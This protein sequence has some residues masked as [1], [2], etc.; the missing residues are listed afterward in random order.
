MIKIYDGRS[1]FYQWDLERQL[2]ISDPI[3]D[4]VHFS[5]KMSDKALVVAVKE[6]DGLRVADV[7]NILLQA[8]WPIRAYAYCGD[9]YTKECATFKVNERTRPD[10]YVYTETEVKRWDALANDIN[11]KVEQYE[12]LAI[13]NEAFLADSGAVLEELQKA[14]NHERR[15][16]QLEK[17]ISNDYFVTD[18]STEYNKIVDANACP[19]AEID[20]VGG[21]SYKSKNLTDAGTVQVNKYAYVDISLSA[22]TMYYLSTYITSDDT[23]DTD[24]NVIALRFVDD[25]YYYISV[26]RGKRTP[27]SFKPS[28]NVNR[29][30]LFAGQNFPTSEGD[31]ATWA[32]IM[33]TTENT[34][35][36]EPYFEGLR[37]TAVSELVSEGA[38]LIPFPYIV[39][40]GTQNGTT[41]TIGD[42]GSIT[43]DKTPTSGFMITFAEWKNG[44]VFNGTYTMSTGVSLPTGTN[45]SLQGKSGTL[46]LLST[47]SSRT[48][49]INGTYSYLKLWVSVDG[50]FSN[51]KLYPMLNY[52][53]TAAPYKPYRAD[54]VDTFTIPEELRAF[55]ADKGYGKGVN[56]DYYNYIDFDRKVFVQRVKE[57]DMGLLNWGY[58]LNNNRHIFN[59]NLSAYSIQGQTSPDIPI[60]A[61]AED[62]RAV[63]VNATWVDRDMAY[64]SNTIGN[65]TIEIVDNRYTNQ[66]D[67]KAAVSGKKLM[68]ALETPIEIDISEYL[69]EDNY[70]EVEAGGTIRAINEYNQAAPTSIT[71][72]L[73][74]GS[75]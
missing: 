65:Q 26:P 62:Y 8:I 9:C 15:I 7:P 13:E 17:H 25:T 70:I 24:E 33:I 66:T 54:A 42:D 63:T 19:Y 49:N 2:I 28:K 20:K 57:V 50:T 39:K 22:G 52:G 10:D 48:L 75:I 61:L 34:D 59:A 27:V 21:M 44:R 47:G 69:T 43:L 46:T 64:N 51:V 74:E 29:L 30:T 41:Y 31:T 40:S 67:F 11:E 5:N 73:K 68:Y 58:R 53:T 3:V 55:L 71:Y 16:T 56:A 32:D 23:D 60:N 6:K 45:L 36:Y 37:D 38:N 12:H 1:E 72:L 18:E 14:E 35:V 4:E